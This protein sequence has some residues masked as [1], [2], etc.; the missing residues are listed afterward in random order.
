M[1]ILGYIG[2]YFN[3]LWT[4]FFHCSLESWTKILAVGNVPVIELKE[5]GSMLEL[6]TV[7]NAK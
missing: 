6:K 7:R 3:D 4:V 2:R 5:P 1:F